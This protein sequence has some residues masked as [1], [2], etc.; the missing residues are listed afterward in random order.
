MARASQRASPLPRSVGLG[1]GVTQRSQA[2]QAAH[3]SEPR[4][5]G[6]R[7]RNGGV[8]EGGGFQH[9][10]W[11]PPR[12]VDNSHSL[13]RRP[14]CLDF[15]LRQPPCVDLYRDSSTQ[16]KGPQ[17]PEGLFTGSDSAWQIVFGVSSGRQSTWQ[18]VEFKIIHECFLPCHYVSRGAPGAPGQPGSHLPADS[19]GQAS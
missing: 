1:A 10:S 17:G 12:G 16:A 15:S 11:T 9:R 18:Y 13:S 7:D 5:G 19:G 2:L 4:A 14:S 3:G 6:L 8:R